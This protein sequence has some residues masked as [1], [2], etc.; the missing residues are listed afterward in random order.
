MLANWFAWHWLDV[1]VRNRC[2]EVLRGCNEGMCWVDQLV[3]DM[4]EVPVLPARRRVF[5]ART[6][7]LNIEGLWMYHPLQ[8]LT[9]RSPNQLDGFAVEMSLKAI[10]TWLGYEDCKHNL[11]RAKVWLTSTLVHVFGPGILLQDCTWDA[12]EYIRTRV[13]NNAKCGKMAK[14]LVEA[15]YNGAQHTHLLFK[16]AQSITTYMQLMH[17]ESIYHLPALFVG[18]HN[19]R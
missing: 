13:L 5:L 9:Y 8:R 15:I 6:Y 7:S 18:I 1:I 19:Q 2:N 16:T 14:A 17:W 12:H 10:S 11:P 3:K 4:R